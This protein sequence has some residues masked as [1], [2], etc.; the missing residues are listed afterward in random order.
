M[1]ICCKFHVLNNIVSMAVTVILSEFTSV[2]R[3][4]PMQI[5]PST[6]FFGRPFFK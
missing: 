5:T 6:Y 4:E 3:L 2:R 1:S